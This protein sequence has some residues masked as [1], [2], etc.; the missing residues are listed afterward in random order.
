MSRMVLC[1]WLCLVVCG[2]LQAADKKDAE[3][4]QFE[5]DWEVVELAEDGHSIPRD[6]IR[7]WL[8]SGGRLEITDNAIVFTSKLDG[9]RHAKIFA[10]DA[11]QYPKGIDIVTPDKKEA[12]GIYRF[13]EGR[14]VVCL[15]DSKDGMRP[16]EFSAKSGSG[17]MLMVLQRVAPAAGGGKT[18]R[19]ERPSATS[20]ESGVAARVLTD[21]DM[22]KLLPGVWRY[23]DDAG[24]LVLTVDGSGTWS[25]I[26][27]SEE[28]RLFQRVFVR[29]PIS[30]GTW[31][32][33]SGT[34]TF[35]CTASIHPD[36][37]N[38]QMSFAIRS[39]SATDFIFIDS[40]GRLGKAVKVAA[41]VPR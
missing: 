17:N 8:P 6:A 37:V 11:T 41:P 3:L 21:S 16:T 40:M 20:T 39:I 29:T 10:I 9:K 14:L 31:T 12:T 27:E 2:A 22:T 18:A 35:L 26:R 7:D 34:L 1:G 5:G 15:S 23:R 33:R 36:R 19:P 4:Q 32:V 13:D 28:L 38:H 30:S 24:A 25:S